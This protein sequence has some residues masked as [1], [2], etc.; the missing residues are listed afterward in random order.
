MSDTPSYPS[1]PSSASP[2][3]SAPTP[4]SS[5]SASAC[6]S[7]TA[8]AYD[9]VAVRYADHV[10]DGLAHLPLDRSFVT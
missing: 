10:K 9:A 6:L 4:P 5:S 1:S 3:S 2:A 7:A 8:E